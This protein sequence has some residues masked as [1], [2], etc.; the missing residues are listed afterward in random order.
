MTLDIFGNPIYTGDVVVF[1]DGDGNGGASLEVYE[2]EELI[3]NNIVKATL[4]SGEYIGAQYYLQNTDKRCSLIRN[5][6][7]T[8]EFGKYD[9]IN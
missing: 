2:V 8:A 6:Y 4:M 5:V 3:G 7:K 9:T 1:A